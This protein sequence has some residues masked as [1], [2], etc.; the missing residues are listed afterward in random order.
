MKK[1]LAHYRKGYGNAAL[2]QILAKFS[3]RKKNR[4][5]PGSAIPRLY[6][7]ARPP[8]APFLRLI[9]K[10]GDALLLRLRCLVPEGTH[11]S[12]DK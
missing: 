11:V 6:I 5:F 3:P 4:R 1:H 8:E 7:V 9:K 2:A 10:E 12:S